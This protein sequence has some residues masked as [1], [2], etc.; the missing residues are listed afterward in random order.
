MLIT[1]NPTQ[2]MNAVS[3][4]GSMYWLNRALVRTG[5][6]GVER[7]STDSYIAT[8]VGARVKIDV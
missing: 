6:S 3:I 2:M 7:K 4:M 1:P 8:M 5:P